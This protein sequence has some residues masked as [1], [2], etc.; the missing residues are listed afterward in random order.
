MDIAKRMKKLLFLN[1]G[2]FCL[3]IKI[4]YERFTP[5]VSLELQEKSMPFNI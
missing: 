2:F 5:I 3:R 1:S 4:R